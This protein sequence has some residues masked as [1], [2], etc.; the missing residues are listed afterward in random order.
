MCCPIGLT[1]YG[2]SGL[3]FQTES[4]NYKSHAVSRVSPTMAYTAPVALALEG[5]DP[6]LHHESL[7]HRPH[8]E[9]AHGQEEKSAKNS[10]TP[11][12]RGLG[13]SPYS[14]KDEV[15]LEAY[16]HWATVKR[17]NDR[18][19]DRNGAKSGGASHLKTDQDMETNPDPATSAPQI[20]GWDLDADKLQAQR[21][22][23]SASWQAVFYLITT[24][25]LGPS[26]APWAFSQLGYAPGVL[27]FF[28]MGLAAAYTGWQL[29]T[30]FMKLDSEQYP[31]RTYSELS[32]RVFG[33]WA[34][35]VVN[36]L[37]TIQLLFNVSVIILGN[38]QGLAQISQYR[39]CFSVLTLIWAFAGMFIGQIRSLKNLGWL[40]NF[41]VWLNLLVIAL[42]MGV[43]AHTLPN[44]AVAHQQNGVS[45]TTVITHAFIH[46]SLNSQIVGIMQIVYSYG[47]AMM[48]IEFMSEMRRPMDFWK[49]MACA[50]V[51]IF[52]C[53]MFF[54]VFVYHF[55]GQF[56]INPGNQGISSYAWQTATNILSLVSA[57]IAAGLYGNI[58]IKVIYQNVVLDLLK[59]PEMSSR[60]GRM[61][62]T[63]L[64]VAYW[65]VAYVIASS[66][67]Q[68][69]NVSGLV[70]AVCILQFTY[71]FPPILMLGFQIQV[72]ATKGDKPFDVAT[73]ATHR[74]DTWR[75][76]SRWRR[77]LLP[78]W[79]IKLFNFLFFLAA[80]VTA[81]LGIYSS[82]QGIIQGFSRQGAASPFG[83]Q[84]PV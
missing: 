25:I 35:H 63:V 84:A 9:S 53:Y 17:E 43:I 3:E 28:F 49:G 23:R 34:Q 57:L 77:G 47:G 71:T 56:T 2:R 30:M 64:V 50:Q 69:S 15:P 51:L 12:E 10:L 32:F 48:F 83:C 61:L 54:G 41:A 68:F 20:L 62:W 67:P 31:V 79:Y 75:D 37:Q 6:R 45:G 74:V 82:V 39:V 38:G 70:A 26:S 11:V 19:R 36:I 72:D 42:T 13:M 44:Y 59:G 78:Q 29:W 16:L 21:A 4:R 46:G 73:G 80:L 18:W 27:M 81:G 8:H 7:H 33:K 76:L 40:A 58:G 66:I 5:S 14:C 65:V 1:I 52:S 60:A 55:Q 22:L 24:D